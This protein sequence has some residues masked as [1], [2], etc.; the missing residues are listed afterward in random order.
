MPRACAGLVLHNTLSEIIGIDSASVVHCLLFHTLDE[1]Q[2]V[3]FISPFRICG[4]FN[5]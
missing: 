3:E 5:A 1:S 4:S 2:G